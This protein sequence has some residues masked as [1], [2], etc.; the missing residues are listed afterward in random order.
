VLEAQPGLGW[1]RFYRGVAWFRRGELKRALD[2][3]ERSIDRMRDLGGAYF[4]LGRLYLAIFLE[5]HRA[6]QHHLSALGTADDLHSARSRLDQAAMAFEEA[7][8][9][10]QELP[11][12]QPRYAEA[13]RHFAEGDFG[14]C[15]GVC[16][17]LLADDPDLEE[18]WRLKGDAERRAGR[19]PLPAYEKAIETR[20]SY[21]EVLLAMGEVH[22]D[23]GRLD[24]ARVSLARALD[25]HSG[26]AAARVLVARTYLAEYTAV[27]LLD[28]LRG[29]LERATTISLEHPA[30]YDAAVTLAEFQLALGRATGDVD[31]LARTLTTLR[32]ADGLPGCGNRVNYLRG[33]ALL[34]RA[35]LR[36]AA[37]GGDRSATRADLDAVLALRD[38]LYAR[39]P[40]AGPWPDLLAAAEQA[41]T[42]LLSATPESQADPPS[43]SR[44]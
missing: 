44:S 39:T 22:L 6:A 19:D 33:C 15:T 10:P 34:T 4:E 21:Y 18:V 29:G 32:R 43:V 11:E 41:L 2:D 42:D 5:E 8:R 1:A 17:A 12:W 14:A 36:M 7:H 23:A 37:G 38:F 27:G 26:L 13:V 35:Q 16:D 30:R 9:L 28:V 31:W 24:E 40:D 3:M 20:R 25:I